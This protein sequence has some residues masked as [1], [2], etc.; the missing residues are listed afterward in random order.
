MIGDQHV[1][2]P[3]LGWPADSAPRRGCRRP[4]H[5]AAHRPRPAPGRHPP[6]PPRPGLAPSGRRRWGL[7]RPRRAGP[8]RR[9]PP[10]PQALLPLR[11][12]PG[13]RRRRPALP[14][15]RRPRRPAHP[16]GARLQ[17]PA[18]AGTGPIGGPP[19]PV[20]EPPAPKRRRRLIVAL[21][22]LVLVLVGATAASFL[23]GR[24]KGPSYPKPVGQ[25]HPAHRPLR[26]A[27]AGPGLQAPGAGAVHDARR[28]STRRSRPRRA[29]CRPRT[30]AQIAEPDRPACGPSGLIDGKVDLFKQENGLNSGGILA[31][32]DFHDKKV[33]VKGTALTPD[34]RVTLAHELTHA[35]QDQYFDLG[36]EDTLPDDAQQAFRSVIEGDAVVVQNA[37]AAHHVPG[38]PGRV[39]QGRVARDRTRP[40]RTCP[41]SWWPRTP[42][43]TSS[44]RRSCEA[45]KARGGNAA[46]DEALETRRPAPPR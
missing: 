41:T 25:P 19:A 23:V 33:R 29:R 9:R 24:D 35:L 15:G 34:V 7:R 14:R 1:R 32:Y 17:A 38:R 28:R 45:L 10:R 12:R 5:P 36:R 22:V 43:P 20:A 26:R 37:Y 30:S 44:A 27:G 3:A 18:R 31:Y 13:P 16:R 21:G 4:A 6:P 46:I 42:S 40:T 39:Q 11:R 8:H 2:E